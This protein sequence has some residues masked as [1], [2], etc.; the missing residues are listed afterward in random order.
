MKKLFLQVFVSLFLLASIASNAGISG[1]ISDLPIY[2]RIY[3]SSRNPNADGR[4][5]LK[6]AKE[7][8]RKVLI[9]VGGDWCSWCHVL[10]RFIKNNPDVEKRLHEMF[11]VLK[12]NISEA[13][14]NAEFMSAFPAAKG[15]PHMYITDSKGT[16][17]YSQDTSYF[18]EN[19]KYSRQRFMAFFER[20]NNDNE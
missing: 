5:A 19:K 15:Y 1:E 6:L 12:V 10:D 14:D 2:S 13:N 20:W 8:Q 4:D 11:V 16:I 3:D 9:E 17:L 18:R 7:T